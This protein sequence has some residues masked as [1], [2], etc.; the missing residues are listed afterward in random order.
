MERHSLDF[1]KFLRTQNTGSENTIN[2]Y[3]HD[4]DGFINFLRSEGINELK[5]V[6]R[7]IVGNYLRS[8]RNDPKQIGRAH[9]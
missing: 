8:L 4:I 2:S 5:D 7:M 3:R 9:V 1:I 6:D